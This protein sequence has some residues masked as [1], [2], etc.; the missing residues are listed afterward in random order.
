M[1]GGLDRDL[2]GL[3]RLPGGGKLGERLGELLPQ[4][5][6][7]LLALP[8]VVWGLGSYS[9]VNG[10]E[11]IYH[12]IAES[13]ARSGN[14]FVLELRGQP[15]LYDT[16][17]NAPI[18]YWAR[19]LLI[20]LFGSSAWTM[21]I[22]SAL[23][24]IA[25]VLATQRLGSYVADRRSGFFAGLALLTT[26]HFVYLHGA[27][28]GELEPALLFF[29]AVAALLF[30]I[31]V[32]R[33]GGWW[34][35]HLCLFALFSLKLP[36]VIIPLAAELAFFALCPRA[37]EHFGA[38]VK[39]GCVLLPFG[40][41]WHLGQTLLRW[42]EFTAVIA[43]MR[44]NASGSSQQGPGASFYGLAGYYARTV[45]FGAFPY[46]LAYPVALLAVLWRSER[47]LAPERDRWRICAL[48]LLA[49][50]GFFLCV[51]QH[52]RWYIMP[53]Y[54]FLSVFLG[55][56][57]SRLFDE[58]P[59][60]LTLG[61]VALVASLAFW[62]RAGGA[63]YNPFAKAAVGISMWTPWRSLAALPDLDPRLGVVLLAL[64]LAGLLFGLR[65]LGSERFPSIIGAIV[66]ALLLGFG[67]LR[68]VQPLAYL[69]YESELSKIRRD[70]AER[71]EAGRPIAHP[72][73]LPKANHFI[74]LYYFAE[75]FDISMQRNP[76]ASPLD[77]TYRLHAKGTRPG[78]APQRRAGGL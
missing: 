34:A 25:A 21:R 26:L 48:Y 43:D 14:A 33:G 53:A 27:R 58:R 18:Q 39:T 60:A 12:G 50:V 1:A 20:S 13:M 63:E 71:R 49:I 29:F 22:L 19:S 72:F 7:V 78:R 45:L 30:M 47:G 70:L 56:W 69:G 11:A 24:A 9:V 38:W 68:V 17:M 40:L 16:W 10:D 6:L 76:S 36:I 59:R 75:D 51:S 42:D 46:S 73:D 66:A 57:L 3:Q 32:E 61:A 44:A 23:F 55:A 62:L 31:G 77:V 64:A 65:A 15:R 74:V 8:L 5:L 2:S 67:T 41:A 4:L 35:H 28:T 52:Y 54:P 37:R